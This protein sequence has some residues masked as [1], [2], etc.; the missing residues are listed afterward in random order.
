M[1]LPLI[2][3]VA[4]INQIPMALN[5]KDGQ[6]KSALFGCFGGF[7]F[8]L[9]GH[10]L[11][12]IKTRMQTGQSFTKSCKGSLWRG[13]MA[14]VTAVPPAWVANF[15]AYSLALEITGDETTLQHAAAGSMSGIVWGASVAPFELVK[16]IAQQENI[17]T[18]KVWKKWLNKN[19]RTFQLTRGLGLTMGRDLFGLGV[20]FGVYHHLRTEWNCSPFFCG[21]GCAVANW[22]FIF[23]IDTLIVR[24]RVSTNSL[25]KDFQLLRKDVIRSPST[26]FKP[27]PIILARACIATATSMMFVGWLRD[28]I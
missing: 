26:F 9:V 1:N 23:P 10:P 11:D 21:G 4:V 22:L 18:K 2:F 16:C 15:V 12:T 7:L 27:V 13:L 8:S 24:Q 25:L 5:A 19:T 6:L 20:W 28:H 3:I 14:P 17:S